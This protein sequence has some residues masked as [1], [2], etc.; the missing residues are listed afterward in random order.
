M[1]AL[2]GELS[3][4]SE[5]Y[6]N[7][8]LPIEA[9]VAD[10]LGRMTP[11][12]KFWQVF[13]VPGSRDDPSHDYRHGAF[14][15]QVD[16]IDTSATA[17]L[18]HAA[19][20]D[21]LQRWFRDSTRLGIPIVPFDE[22]LHGLARPGA[23]AFPQAIALAATWDTAL[24]GAVATA[25]A[26]ETASRGIRQALSPVVNITRD[27]RWGRT[28]ETYGEDPVLASAM[29]VA[30]VTPFER[31]GIVT[32]PKHFVANVGEGGRDSW[33]IEVSE[34]QL[35][36]VWF[37]PF[38][39]AITS[40][41]A[42]AVM[43]AYNS[44]D[45]MPASQHRWL[46]TEVLRDRWRFDGVVISD[47][48]ATAGATVLHRT[49]ASVAT[50]ARRALE[51]GLD[52]VFQSSWEQHGPW[53]RAFTD[54]SVPEALIDRAVA[55]VLRL[56][57][58]LGLFDEAGI[59]VDV[60]SQANGS[61][62]HRRL[63]REVAAASMVLLHNTGVLPLRDSGTVAL[64]GT[65]A[66][67]VR[68]GGYSGPGVAPVSIRAALTHRLGTDRV[69]YLPGPGRSSSA[70][71]PVPS[72]AL[73]SSDGGRPIA[74]LRGEYFVGLEPVGTP[75]HV[76]FDPAVQFHWTFVEPAPGV[77][78][79]WYAVRW[80]GAIRIPAGE[81]QQLAIEGDEGYRLWI[82]GRLV[83]DRWAKGRWGRQVAAPLLRGGTQ[84]AIRLEFHEGM[85][86]GRIA[87]QWRSA[88][89][90]QDSVAVARAVAAAATADVA[91]VVAGIEEGEFRDR[92]SLALPGM[93][94]RLIRDVAA[95]GTPV[96]VVIVG[97]AP[98]TMA[99]LDD[100]GAVVM[101]WYPGEQGG[102][103]VADVLL[104]DADPGG[105][106]PITFPQSEGQLPL[107]YNH[108]PTGRGDDYLDQA[109]RPLFPFGH[110]LSYTSFTFSDLRLSDSSVA[111]GDSV[112]VS[113][114]VRNTGARTGVVVPQLYLH[115][116]LASIAQPVLAL[117][118]FARRTLPPGTSEQVQWTI[119]PNDL[120]LLD[121]DRR[122]VVEP[123]SF[124]LVV[125]TSARDARL[126]GRLS[127]RSR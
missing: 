1:L 86:N 70:W 29:G 11:E 61:P 53:L 85:G 32:T 9:R 102:E 37:P 45:G 51:A 114:V 78:I 97:G 19:R 95:T 67:T 59:D 93:Q 75:Q 117:R 25:I 73:T 56:K 15:L 109:G 81:S 112:V 123:G 44:V 46:L 40:G 13:M 24:V 65:D 120:A 79:D 121:V 90:A 41:G 116:E 74:G 91:V 63:A 66:D 5:A 36:E 126:T 77:P 87:L 94:E 47:A 10:L 34:R 72:T 88:E 4:Q 71:L 16:A 20:I 12:E 125:G 100:V 98:V 28:E 76:R 39:A 3:A 105:R 17:A 50:S 2:T 35:E 103:A 83:L 96:V 31:R 62:A 68:L 101:A 108:K 55:R 52:V 115:D 106:L 43:S 48:A 18:S 33:P 80:T 122:Q 57:F 111:V 60:A 8:A 23:T 89:P 84:H 42:R 54:G 30:F 6:R 82:D 69:R 92:A 113:F 38:R 7:P 104:G 58:A 49:E 107:Y 118:R 27:A 14:G 99:W 26:E 119:G 124:R 64:I 110:G 22:A 127:V 21:Q